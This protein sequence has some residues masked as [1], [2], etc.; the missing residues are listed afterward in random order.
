MYLDGPPLTAEIQ[1]ASDLLFMEEKLPEDFYL[2]IDGRPL[3]FKF[4]CDNLKRRYRCEYRDDHFNGVIELL[5]DR[6]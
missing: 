5:S 4:L 6:S 2:V 1:S 3:N